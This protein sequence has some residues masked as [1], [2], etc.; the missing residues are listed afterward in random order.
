MGKYANKFAEFHDALD[1][2]IYEFKN[3]YQLNGISGDKETLRLNAHKKKIKV[4]QLF[5]KVLCDLQV[6][7]KKGES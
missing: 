1:E 6:I 4:L 7:E 5:G 3:L 2:C